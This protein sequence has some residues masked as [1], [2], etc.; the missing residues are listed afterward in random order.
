MCEIEKLKDLFGK[1]ADLFDQVSELENELNKEKNK[2][3]P[4]GKTESKKVCPLPTRNIMS[5]ACEKWITDPNNRSLF[6]FA[7]DVAKTYCALEDGS[8]IPDSDKG[9]Q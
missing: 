9:C 7:Q 1:V 2:A 4:S 5:I 3:K 6:Y 8:I